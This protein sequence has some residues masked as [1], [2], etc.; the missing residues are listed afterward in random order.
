MDSLLVRLKARNPRMGL[1][2]RDYS[3]RFNKPGSPHHGTWYDFKRAMVWHRVPVEVGERLRT[4]TQDPYRPSPLLF[5][6][7]TDAEAKALDHRAAVERERQRAIV[8]PT[9]DTAVDLT[10]GAAAKR[11]A[12]PVEDIPEEVDLSSP[13]TDAANVGRG[14]L[15]PSDL[16]RP[17]VE[18][19]RKA[20]LEATRTRKAPE[21]P[22]VPAPDPEPPVGHQDPGT[23]VPDMT[24]SRSDLADYAE[25][26]GVKVTKGMV[27]REILAAL[28]LKP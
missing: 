21:A 20:A 7:C 2:A 11:P 5:D 17:S 9:V 8:E 19:S 14:D 1:K 13:M 15:R 3:I 4:V 16:S 12:P 10:G 18:A 25:D 27:K 24:W 22:M 6:V 23:D 26:R 28:G